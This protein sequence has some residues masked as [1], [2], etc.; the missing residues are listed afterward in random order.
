MND[1]FLTQRLPDVRPAFA[2][3]L[4]GKL[5]RLEQRQRRRTYAVASALVVGLLFSLLLTLPPVRA[6]VRWLLREI[7]GVKFVET[8]NPHEDWEAVRT[9]FYTPTPA[10]GFDGD[11]HLERIVK[12]FPYVLDAPV[13]KPDGYAQDEYVN[14]RQKPEGT[15]VTVSWHPFAYDPRETY[16]TFEIQKMPEGVSST[17]ASF[18]GVAGAGAET[19]Y[20]GDKTATLWHFPSTNGSDR[21]AWTL[22]WRA[23]KDGERFEYR[24]SSN[25]LHLT[26][27]DM[28][29]MVNT[30]GFGWYVE[31]IR[32]QRGRELPMVNLPEVLA[33]YPELARFLPT[34]LPEG[35]TL[36]EQAAIDPDSQRVLL[37]W[38]GNNVDDSGHAP[39]AISMSM[40]RPWDVPFVVKPD[41]VKE[42]TVG[43]TVAAMWEIEFLRE[44]DPDG[45]TYTLCCPR[46]DLQYCISWREPGVTFNDI[47][48][49]VESIPDDTGVLLEEFEFLLE[50]SP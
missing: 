42:V 27:E 48:R 30:T 36:E 10:P 37:G 49:V 45:R 32:Q 25:D 50:A 47:V 24:L 21:S 39:I 38:R 20:L 19:I 31:K 4:R 12:A 46:N 18:E 40:G 2:K 41:T 29:R 3:T 5:H 23:E 16:I 44:W 8:E 13:W 7:G 26:R 9:A 14:I 33:A 22:V 34:W 28:L 35:F 11:Y 43:N 15:I 1:E 6:Q 17:P